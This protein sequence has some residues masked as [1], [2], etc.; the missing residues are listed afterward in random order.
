MDGITAV[1]WA[2]QVAKIPSDRIVILGH[3]LGTAVTS[4]VV[5]HFAEKETEFAGVVLVS[6]FTDLPNLLT[7]YSI[8][9]YLPVLSP[10]RASPR[11]YK[12]FASYAVDKW[13]S[14]TRL[15]NFVRLSKKVRLFIIHSKDDYEIPWT[16]SEGLFATAANATTDG[17]MDIVLLKQMKVRTTIEMDDGASIST[18]KAGGNK[19]IQEEIVAYGRK[20]HSKSLLFTC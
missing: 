7:S 3:S 15:A 12:F 19:I 1:N 10:L 6:G 18:W 2:L 9:G 8:A 16:H 4:A 14:A 11:L 17:G 5:E 13:P 20:Q